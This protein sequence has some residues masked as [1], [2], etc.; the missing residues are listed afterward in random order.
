MLKVI[1]SHD[2]YKPANTTIHTLP[3]LPGASTSRL[4]FRGTTY[5]DALLAHHPTTNTRPPTHKRT[6]IL[7]FRC[8]VACPPRARAS[9]ERPR[10]MHCY[11]ITPRQTQ[12]K[13][14]H[15]FRCPVA[16][17]CQR[18][19]V[20][21]PRVSSTRIGKTHHLKYV[22]ADTMQT[23]THRPAHLVFRAWSHLCSTFATRS[24]DLEL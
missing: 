15:R 12:C 10:T 3:F 17:S 23:Q 13:Y 18:A 1:Q 2:K 11:H 22:K 8:P 5:N 19:S 24:I 7:C 20:E 4:R 16:C 9:V 21:R 6:Y 14:I